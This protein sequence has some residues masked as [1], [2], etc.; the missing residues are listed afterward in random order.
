MAIEVN[1]TEIVRIVKKGTQKITD[2]KTYPKIMYAECNDIFVLMLGHG[3]G[4]WLNPDNG[5]CHG[6]IDTRW[7]MKHFQDFTGEIT[8]RNGDE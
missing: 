8:L 1:I 5:V 7:N 3:V 4:I 2:I 6:S